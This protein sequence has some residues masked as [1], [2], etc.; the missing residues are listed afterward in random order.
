MFDVF[1][2]NNNQRRANCFFGPQFSAEL[3]WQD[4]F[5]FGRSF[6][7]QQ[8]DPPQSLLGCPR[9]GSLR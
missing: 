2:E 9:A 3:S 5:W 1:S 6:L 4:I 8:S 7:S